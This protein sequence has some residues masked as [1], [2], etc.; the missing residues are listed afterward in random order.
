[1]FSQFLLSELPVLCY[2]YYLSGDQIVDI[3]PGEQPSLFW[4]I[5]SGQYA[6]ELPQLSALTRDHAG[7]IYIDFRIMQNNCSSA[8]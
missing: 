4:K 8:A 5:E 6:D 7:L 1:M 3:Y 2:I